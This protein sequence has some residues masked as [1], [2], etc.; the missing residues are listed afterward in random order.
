MG[1]HTTE[2]GATVEAIR[3]PLLLKHDALA[4]DVTIFQRKSEHH[5]WKTEVGGCLGTLADVQRP[6]GLLERHGSCNS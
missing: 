2:L 4:V 1:L 3:Y 6:L 5:A